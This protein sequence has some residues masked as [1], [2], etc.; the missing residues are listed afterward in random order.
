MLSAV[1]EKTV[2]GHINWKRG[3]LVLVEHV[4]TWMSSAA[5][6]VRSGQKSTFWFAVVHERMRDDDH[7]VP[8]S[9]LR[10]TDG[11]VFTISVKRKDRRSGITRIVAFDRHDHHWW[12][13]RFDAGVDPLVKGSY[14][15]PD[16][17]RAEFSTLESA[18]DAAARFIGSANAVAPQKV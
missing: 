2:S 16:S 17:M 3:D 7:W 1:A 4:M 11:A 12:V 18:K 8:R 9:V 5:S 13:A 10:L 15:W 6:G 14:D